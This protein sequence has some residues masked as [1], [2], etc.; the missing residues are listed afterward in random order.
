[1]M[2]HRTTNPKNA[3]YANYGGRGIAV[4]PQW[5]N[6][7]AAFIGWLLQNIG[8]RPPERTLDRI[9]VN[10]NYEPGNLRWAT[11][12]EQIA[13]RQLNEQLRLLTEENERLRVEVDALRAE[14]AK[15][16]GVSTKTVQRNRPGPSGP[17]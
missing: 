17:A 10:G 1:M 4:C 8:S 13:N 7:P 14:V 3:D 9:D 16:A 6:D 15:Q 2:V 12:A 5:R 11:D